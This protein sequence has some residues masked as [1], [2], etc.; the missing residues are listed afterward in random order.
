MAVLSV[1]KSI[2]QG[3]VSRTSR[4][5]TGHFRVSQFPLFLKNG[6]DL[7]R[8]FS[9]CYLENMLK[10]RLSKT[11]SWQFQKCLFGPEKFS[12]VTFEK[13]A[14]APSWLDS[15]VGRAVLR[16]RGVMGPNPFQAWI[17]QAYLQSLSCL[18]NCADFS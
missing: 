16:N 4:I 13:R 6:K 17:F 2:D 3:P 14:S 18:S 15:S 8:H 12:G 11:S 10:D 1:K 7:S 5:F 9:I